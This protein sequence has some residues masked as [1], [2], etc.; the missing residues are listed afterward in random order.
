VRFNVRNLTN[1]YALVDI[2]GYNRES[3]DVPPIL[4]TVLSGR[5]FTLGVDRNF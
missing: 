1:K 5:L 3:F 4:A 2:S